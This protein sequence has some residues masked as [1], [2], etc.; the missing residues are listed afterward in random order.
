VE[1]RTKK[2]EEGKSQD[3]ESEKTPQQE[4][5]TETKS[6]FSWG[7]FA[8]FLV[9]IAV[10]AGGFLFYQNQG[11]SQKEY[12]FSERDDIYLRDHRMY[13][14][15]PEIERGDLVV[16]IT[17]AVFRIK[18]LDVITNP[19]PV[20]GLRIYL[21]GKRK[22]LY[23]RGTEITIPAGAK[24]RHTGGSEILGFHSEQRVVLEK[25][26]KIRIE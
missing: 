3:Q 17:D 22:S 23:Y 12:E 5:K 9:L 24:F 19:D 1:Y 15:V 13:F 8:V 18:P 25:P 10:I 2:K 14:R 11:S 20:F 26:F 4:K 16:F 21:G 7:G 6:N